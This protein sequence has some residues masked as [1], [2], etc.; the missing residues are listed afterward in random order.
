MTAKDYFEHD[1]KRETF[2]R[3]FYQSCRHF[4]MTLLA[5]S[6]EV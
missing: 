6:P 2:S 5:A 4:H 3:I 1:P